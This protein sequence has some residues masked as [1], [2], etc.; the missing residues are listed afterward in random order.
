MKIVL[1]GHLFVVIDSSAVIMMN[2]VFI[3][4]IFSI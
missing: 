3:L 4:F 2:K 1:K